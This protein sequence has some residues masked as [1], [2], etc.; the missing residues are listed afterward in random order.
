MKTVH[1]GEELMVVGV[2]PPMAA[3]RRPGK[4]ISV[5]QYRSPTHGMVAST[6]RVDLSPHYIS[7]KML[8]QTV[9]EVCLLGDSKYS[10]TDNED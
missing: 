6:F 7:L 2:V 5:I 3:M 8:L 9:V 10:E 4:E 1:H